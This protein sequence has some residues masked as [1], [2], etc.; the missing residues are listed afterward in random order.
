MIALAALRALPLRTWGLIG[1]ALGIAALLLLVH[2]RTNERDAARALAQANRAALD[3]TVAD[4]RAAREDA[5]RDDAANAARV[6]REQAAISQE[7]DDDYA[8]RIAAL[9]ADFTRRVHAATPSADRGG[10]GNPAMPK[11]AD[12]AGRIDDAAADPGLPSRQALI[13][14]EQAE[15]LVALQAWVARQTRI[16]ASPPSND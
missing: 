1:S 5:A 6:G 9:R 12:A 10:G 13:A 4:Y 3:R 15:Q 8:Q 16:E 14:S 7:I 11:L 2:V